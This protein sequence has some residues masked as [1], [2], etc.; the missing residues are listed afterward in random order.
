MT[1]ILFFDTETTE[2]GKHLI[3]IG[4]VSEDGASLHTADRKA[5]AAFAAEHAYLCGHNILSHDLKYVKEELQ[6]GLQGTGEHHYIDTLYLSPLLF[7]SHPYHHLLKNDKLQTGELNN[8]VNDSRKAKDLL[9]DEVTAF[10][11]L[12]TRIQHIFSA[13]LYQTPEFDGFFRYLGVTPVSDADIHSKIAKS[14][15]A[16]FR[17][18]ICTNADVLF[19]CKSHPIELAY[20]LALI[21]TED[22]HTAIAPWVAMNYPKV[23]TIYNALCNTPCHTE[24]PYCREHFDITQKL[25]KFFGY[26]DFRTYN[27]EPLQKQAAQAAVEGKS[28][29]AVFP[30]GGGKSLTF[31][32]PALIAGESAHGLTVVI[33]PLQ[34]LMKDQVDNLKERGIMEAATIN[35]SLS[36]VERQAAIDMVENG[37]ASILYIA[38]ESLRSASVERLLK[39]RNVVRFVIDEAH[40][41][42]A[43]GQDFRVD[44]RFIGPFIKKLQEEKGLVKPIPVSC[45]T[46]TAKQQ[47]ISDIREYFRTECGLELEMFTTD[48]ARTNL[49]YEVLPRDNDEEKYATLRDLILAKDCPTIVYVSRTKRTV[50]LAI[51]LTEDGI[52]AVP[53]HGQMDAVTK[54]TNQEQF[55]SGGVDVVVATT[56]FGMG[57]DKDDVGLVVH[58]NIS[59]SLEDYVQEA[60]RAGRDPRMNAE[61]FI[62]FDEN[63]LD[64]HFQY[65]NETKLS[66]AEIKQIWRG[67][68][69]LAGGRERFTK[70]PLEIARTAGWDETSPMMETKVKSAVAALEQA[71]YIRRGRN[72]PR[73]YATGLAVHNMQEAADDIRACERFTDAEKQLGIEIMNFLVS[74]RSHARAGTDEDESRIDYI[75]D[76]LGRRINEVMYMVIRLREAGILDDSMDMSVH[77]EQ[78]EKGVKGK[79][80]GI[81]AM[82][83]YLIDHLPDK[84]VVTLKELN[85]RA[86]ED[87]IK[88]CS[89][90]H[91]KNLLLF[92]IR[93]GTLQKTVIKDEGTFHI[94]K[95]AD[96]RKVREEYARR[97]ELAMF[98]AG[99][100]YSKPAPTPS[101][102]EI[103]FS[104]LELMQAYNSRLSLLDYPQATSMDVVKALIYLSD[105]G[106]MMFDGGF[107]VIYNAIQ[108]ERLI[109][110]NLIQYKKDDY[111]LFEEYYIQRRQQIH[112]VGE[113][114]RLMAEDYNAAMEFVRDYFAMDY[115]LFIRKYFSQERRAEINRSITAER[116]NKL[117]DSLSPMQ[118]RI[119]D[120]DQSQHIVV[121]AGPGSGKT[122]VLVHKLASQLLLEDVRSEQLL[123]LTFSRSAATEFKERLIELIGEAAFFVDIRTFHSYCFN[124]LGQIGNIDESGSVVPRATAMIRSGEIETGKI[125]KTVL[126]LDEAQ[127]M[128]EHEFALVEALLERNEDMRIIAVGDDDQNI[129][130]FR[131]SDSGYL[132]ALVKKYGAKQYELVDNY[133]SDRAIVD[134]ANRFAEGMRVRMKTEPIRAVSDDPG[135]VQITK[136]ATGNLA[137]PTMHLVQE[138]YRGGTCCVMTATNEEALMMTGILN[139]NGLKAKLIQSSDEFNLDNLYELRTFLSMLGDPAAQPVIRQDVWEAALL[140]FEQRFAHS[141]C[142][143]ECLRLLRAFDRTSDEKYYSDLVEFI[144][145]SKLEDFTEQ[146]TDT[147]LVSTIHKSKGRQF[148]AVYMMLNLFNVHSDADRHVLYVGMTR[149][150]KR[151]YINCNNDLFDRLNGRMSGHSSSGGAAFRMDRNPYPEPDEALLQLRMKGVNLGYFKYL[152]HRQVDYLAGQML[153]EHNG[154]LRTAPAGGLC[155]AKLS[156]NSMEMIQTLRNKGFEI[157]RS[158]IRFLVYWKGKNEKDE[159]LCVLPDVYLR[160]KEEQ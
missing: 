98:I 149:A 127:D 28:L 138:T 143:P 144:R 106:A 78:T 122:K 103:P 145:E 9:F 13:L 112:I 40:C 19:F 34:S 6:R 26:K 83:K 141:T 5:F 81:A 80:S 101:S 53:Y 50:E 125:T 79:L 137:V 63:D 104:I 14:I 64:L 121:A 84:A 37:I 92:W 150:Q 102:T 41:F 151:L 97:V 88:G 68:K 49:R 140:E 119:I 113:Y 135:L 131:G 159:V 48:A 117:F 66:I 17:D 4:A 72:M 44:Y 7:P 142:L 27:G 55:M 136:Y 85:T 154:D 12:D 120:D 134:F 95:K 152:R 1:K 42:S 29:L 74:R 54:R 110:D 90:K 16:V 157:Y 15:K 10:H 153:W 2:D 126:V 11:Q 46:A 56:A 115:M 20:C 158:E 77:L 24:C 129:Y 99:Y 21:H 128:N 87:G 123:M 33:S 76:R 61:C 70:T 91:L 147:I 107:L 45:F 116:Y 60:G 35:G 59:T 109:M 86:A 23:H 8:P 93:Q 118:R 130:E 89:T 36:P 62:L 139:K 69:S 25:R 124:L 73:I 65:L 105:I 94:E 52:P 155:L 132:K 58:Y 111:R 133:R 148:E 38:P 108:V 57:I 3:D 160:K 51:R 31:Q 100:L 75:A 156:R 47:V 18:Q 32:L 114:A 43:W 22:Q 30:T 67:I 146:S 71:G 39:A 96:F 82:E